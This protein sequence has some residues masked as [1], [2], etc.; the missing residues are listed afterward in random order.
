MIFVAIGNRFD[1]NFPL[2]DCDGKDAMA[3]NEE[4]F[5]LMVSGAGFSGE[6]GMGRVDLGGQ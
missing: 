2:T 4:A 3:G 5:S 1:T 6:G